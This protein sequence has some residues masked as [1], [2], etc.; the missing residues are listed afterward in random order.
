MILPLANQ[1]I[2]VWADTETDSECDLK[3]HGTHRYAQHPTT[4]LQLFSYAFD[5]GPV[6]L[7]SP[8]DGEP[9]PADL[10]AAFENPNAIFWF[11]NAWFDRN[12]I[13]NCLKIVLPLERFRCV[14][15]LALSHALPAGLEKLGEVLGLP[16]D[17]QKIKDGKRLVLKFCKPKKSK[18]GE[19]TWATPKTDPDDWARYKEY[20]VIDTASMRAAAKKIPR[21]NYKGAELDYWFMDQ[22]C[23]SRG[24][25]IDLEF[26]EKAMD[27]IALNQKKL[28][29][30]THGL[31]DGEVEAA[32]QRDAMLRHIS[33]QYGYDLPDM[34]KSTLE[35]ML[36]NDDDMPP[37]L[38]EL[39]Q[40]RLSTSTTSTAKYKKIMDVVSNG[41]RVHGTIQCYG[42]S[43]TLRDAGRL[44]QIQNYARPTL[45]D[46][47]IRTGIEVIRNQDFDTASE[48][49]DLVGTDVMALS[50][51]ALRYS[52]VAKPGYKFCIADLSNIEGRVLAY[53]ANESWKIKAFRDY[54]TFQTDDSGQL[55]LDAKGKPLRNGPD[56]YIASYASSFK[57][58]IS[59]VSK[60]DRQVGKVLELS[61]GFAGGAGAIV[62]FAIM[63]GLDL[64]ELA[65]VIAPTIPD[66][67]WEDAKG[68]YAWIAKQNGGEV[69]ND[70]SEYVFAA[71]DSTKRLWRAGHPGIVQFWKDTEDAVRNAIAIPKQRFYFGNG[72]YAIRS[73]SWVRLVLPSGHNLCYPMMQVD[74]DGKLRF[75]G[76]GQ[77]SRKWEWIYT[78]SGR[79][80]ENCVQAF[81]RD[82]FKFG[83]LKAEK[84]GYRVVMPVHDELVTE[85]P[86][87]DTYSYHQLEEIMS[88]NPPW[89]PDIPLSAEGM[90]DY[91]YHK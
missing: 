65:D 90:E 41:G 45:D 61:L 55:I 79:L 85:V 39:L 34:R 31:T 86:D 16:Q 1:T 4:H 32:S 20:C 26:V 62:A 27:F 46:K 51:S 3:K 83:Q 19:L 71:L 73:G 82:I 21:W 29:K 40:I 88:T 38:R 76:V 47:T 24:M 67:V 12:I 48:I 80:T 18:T 43:R 14:M 72:L 15:A 84:A 2:N 37:V 13:E 66:N 36:S 52:I 35:S 56:I 74:K 77:Y 75:R 42:A 70:L 8:R 69:P 10:K 54:D 9:M 81:A 64:D 49:F 5:D 33:K 25:A 28:A 91:R 11:H 53:L 23:N 7:W 50:S 22:E 6:K 89:A 59:K 63:Y 68:L 17:L 60:S 30:K 78:F 58:D 44:T 87:T 57:V